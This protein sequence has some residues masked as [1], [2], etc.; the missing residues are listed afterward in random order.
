M[1]MATLVPWPVVP[2]AMSPRRGRRRV[3]EIVTPLLMAVVPVLIPM[4]LHI[5]YPG[6]TVM[7]LPGVSLDGGM[8][9]CRNRC[10]I[11]GKT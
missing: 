6:I 7:L 2:S 4:G 3:M 11:D 9:R 1:D 5:A 8:R 10:G